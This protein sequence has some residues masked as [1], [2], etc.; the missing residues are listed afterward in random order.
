[1]S[2]PRKLTLRI[3]DPLAPNPPQRPITD[4]GP[5]PDAVER[6]PEPTAATTPCCE[7]DAVG[8]ASR[9]W[10]SRVRWGGLGERRAVGCCG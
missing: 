7:E 2:R 6:T 3:D 8:A 9:G 4:D 5:H 10:R 1:M